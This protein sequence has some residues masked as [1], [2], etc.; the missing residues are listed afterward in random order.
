MHKTYDKTNPKP[1]DG[2]FPSFLN[3]VQVCLKG[4]CKREETSLPLLFLNDLVFFCTLLFSKSRVPNFQKAGCPIFKNS[5]CRLT[6]GVFSFLNFSIPYLHFRYP[7]YISDTLLIFSEPSGYYRYPSETQCLVFLIFWYLT[8]ICDTLLI[9]S[10]L[11]GYFRY[12]ILIP[13]GYFGYPIE[14]QG[15][16]F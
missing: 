4:W 8:Y 11:S 7:S 5:G 16:V 3:Q 2:I 14:S 1:L 9:F 12:P 6:G 10:I 15:L 13:S